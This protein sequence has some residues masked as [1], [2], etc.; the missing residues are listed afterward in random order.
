MWLLQCYI[1]AGRGPEDFPWTPSSRLL[2]P[3]QVCANRGKWEQSE[4]SPSPLSCVT[5]A[6]T[7]PNIPTWSKWPSPCLTSMV[8]QRPQAGL[9]PQMRFNVV[10]VIFTGAGEPDQTGSCQSLQ[11]HHCFTFTSWLL[12]GFSC[13]TQKMFGCRWNYL[14]FHFVFTIVKVCN[15]TKKSLKKKGLNTTPNMVSIF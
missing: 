5:P 9:L 2:R 3:S 15:C 10:C 11:L 14:S 12:I 8:G 1:S 13:R 6:R 4:P 7:T